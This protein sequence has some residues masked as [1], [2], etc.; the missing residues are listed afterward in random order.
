MTHRLGI[1][2]TQG[3]VFAIVSGKERNR[4]PIAAKIAFAAAGAI[5]ACR[6]RRLL[7]WRRRN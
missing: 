2:D 4:V 6:F 5:A 3:Y 1:I 7:R